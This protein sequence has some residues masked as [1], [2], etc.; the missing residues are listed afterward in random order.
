MAYHV[1][2]RKPAK[3]R[4]LFV[5]PGLCLFLVGGLYLIW[6]Q[7]RG[8]LCYYLWTS[9]EMASVE[10]SIGGM[11][12]KPTML[13]LAGVLSM[14]AAGIPLLARAASP[15]HRAEIRRTAIV[16][17]AERTKVEDLGVLLPYLCDGDES[18]R[19]L[20][21]GLLKTEHFREPILR[22]ALSSLRTARTADCASI[23]TGLEKYHASFRSGQLLLDPAIALY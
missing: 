17:L 19:G 14:R 20:V 4:V 21:I 15:E 6:L 10:L 23:V 18:V 7:I 5:L 16:L 8:P 11:R 22:G 12:A 1:E 13:G 9:P 3:R 2:A